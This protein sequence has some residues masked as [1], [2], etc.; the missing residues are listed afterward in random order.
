MLDLT[1]AQGSGKMNVGEGAWEGSFSAK[2]RFEGNKEGTSPEKLITATHTGSFSMAFTHALSEAGHT[3][4]SVETKAEASIAK[5]ADGFNIT[6]IHL[7]TKGK[8]P[9][10]KKDEFLQIAD[11]TKENCRYPKA[12]KQGVAISLDASLES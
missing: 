7:T 3:P 2:S 10:I 11:E 9:G 6:K 8:V 12:L 5:G 4:D 1:L